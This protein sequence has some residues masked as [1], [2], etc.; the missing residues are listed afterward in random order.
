MR[1]IFLLFIV[2]VFFSC[3]KDDFITSADAQLNISTDTLKFDTVFTT[4]GS[5]TQRFKIR[6]DNDRKLNIST[7]TLAG[8]AT[9]SYQ[10]NINGIAANSA[11]NVVLAPN[12]SLYVF[13]KV[14]I[15]PTAANL[16]FVVQDS[17]RIQFNGNIR[18]VQ[19]QAYGQNAR[20]LSNQKI[21]SNT[22][23][24]NQLPYVILGGLTVDTFATLTI[25]KGT[26]IYCHANAPFIVNGSLKAT[27]D[28]NSRISFQ[29]DRLDADYKDLPAGWPGIVFTV[30]SK[31]NVLNFTNV[32]NAYQA[33][34]VAGGAANALPKLTLNEC[35]IDNAYDVGLYGLNTS[36]QSRN[37]LFSNCGNDAASGSG[38]SNLLLI[39]GNYV[40]NHATVATYAN[41]YN[42]HKQPVVFISNSDGFRTEP[43]TALFRNSIIYGEGGLVDDE[44]KVSNQNGST[45]S[46]TLNNVLYKA[47]NDI[48]GANITVT[49]SLRNGEPLFD[50]INTFRRIFD[51][52]LRNGSPAI[53]AGDTNFSFTYDLDGKPRI[54]ATKPDLGCY[55]TQ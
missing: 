35:I 11:T 2:P 51:F 27:G 41:S 33:L 14:T 5:V 40:F 16:P 32:K 24:N 12:D 39:A 30:F 19:L 37:C 3:T 45:F 10:L 48:A 22:V 15:N 55:E 53:N 18:W 17:I 36:V 44:I 21:T 23:W 42:S 54:V 50:T 25:G 47:K 20:F 29:G 9:G 28:S 49:N 52:R 1:W 8:G 34:V 38:G 7:I 31:E 6:N 4:A 43:L 13:V 26:R 46:L